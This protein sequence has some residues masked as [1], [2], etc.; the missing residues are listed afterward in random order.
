MHR[1]ARASVLAAL[2][3]IYD[4]SWTR[5]VGTDGGKTLAW[6]GKL[7]LI[8]GCTP[9]IDRHHAAIAALGERFAMYRLEVDDPK[10]QARRSLTHVGRERQMRAELQEAVAGFFAGVPS[11][12]AP[13]ERTVS[14]TERLVALAHL[15]AHARSA[16]DREGFSSREIEL[17]PDAE[18]PGRLVGVLANMLD[19]LRTIGVGQAEAWRLVTK[20]GLDSM[21]GQRRRIFEHALR[22]DS[23]TTKKAAAALGLPT[24]TTRRV[25]EDLTAHGVMER[26][27]DGEGRADIWKIAPWARED[28]QAAVVP[29]MSAGDP[30]FQQKHA[31]DDISGT[32]GLAKALRP[33]AAGD[34]ARRIGEDS[35]GDDSL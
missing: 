2:R 18:A 3:E 19:G 13:P 12:Q 16:V 27:A 5:H 33:C 21:P 26:V 35:A 29:E 30:S 7:G 25:L 15:V 17:V 22:S 32:S 28:Y 20:I 4:G 31:F 14:D 6:Q 9:A 34:D 8:A 1:D 24:N 10:A 11:T 23:T